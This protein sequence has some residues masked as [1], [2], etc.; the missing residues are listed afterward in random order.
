MSLEQN[1]DSLPQRDQER[2][3]EIQNSKEV[4]SYEDFISEKIRGTETHGNF[5]MKFYEDEFYEKEE[6][7]YYQ[8]FKESHPELEK[9]I[10]DQVKIIGKN[11]T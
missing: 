7:L 9:Y 1:F 10:V 11:K 4:I 3:S 5:W 8:R 6:R 2:F